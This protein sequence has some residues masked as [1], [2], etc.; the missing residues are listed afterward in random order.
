MKKGFSSRKGNPER[1]PARKKK[2]QGNL[3]RK[4]KRRF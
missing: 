1:A 4:K 2:G 3:E